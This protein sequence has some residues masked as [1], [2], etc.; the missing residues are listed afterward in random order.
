MQCVGR[1]EC[2]SQNSVAGYPLRVQLS[3]SMSPT[4][5]N[6]LLLRLCV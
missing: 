6:A 1:L 5:C 2:Y 3:Q 4:H